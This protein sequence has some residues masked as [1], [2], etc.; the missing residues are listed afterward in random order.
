MFKDQACPLAG[1]RTRVQME[2]PGPKSTLFLSASILYCEGIY[3]YVWTPIL[4]IQ[5]LNPSQGN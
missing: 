3:A 1:S 5:A 4:N 2:G